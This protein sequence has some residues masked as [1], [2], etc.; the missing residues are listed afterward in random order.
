MALLL[1]A[2][3]QFSRAKSGETWAGLADD[4]LRL[5]KAQS[6]YQDRLGA[7]V[8]GRSLNDTLKLLLRA[9][10]LKEFDDV[11]KKFKVPERRCPHLS[12]VC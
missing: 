12:F 2:A 1:Q 8:L 4:Q 7:S 9:S 11:V 5:M 3:K 6:G 10:D